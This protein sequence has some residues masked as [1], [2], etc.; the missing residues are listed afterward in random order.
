MLSRLQAPRLGGRVILGIPDLYAAYVLPPVLSAF[1]LAYPNVD[2]EIRC[3]L[4][5]R[6][7]T[8]ISRDEID[9]ALVTRMPAFKQG[10]VVAQ[11]PL[12]WVAGESGLAAADEPVALGDAATWEYFPRP[13]A[14]GSRPGRPGVGDWCVSAKV[15]AGIQAAVLGGIAVSA[16]GASSVIPG[17]ACAPGATTVFRRLPKVGSHAL[18]CRRPRQSGVRCL[19]RYHRPLHFRQSRDRPCRLCCTDAGRQ[20][21]A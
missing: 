17:N 19:D 15:S 13:R 3:S 1:N 12:V 9:V 6:L 7:M 18:S 11:E 20:W 10:L 14:G 21:G 2:L 4:S 16:V 8:A 5:N